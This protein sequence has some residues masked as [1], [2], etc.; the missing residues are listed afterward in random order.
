[1]YG[2]HVFKQCDKLMSTMVKY[3]YSTIN[4]TCYRSK[5]PALKGLFSLSS[6]EQTF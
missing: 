6:H 1:M 4:V 2:D 3:L 5:N